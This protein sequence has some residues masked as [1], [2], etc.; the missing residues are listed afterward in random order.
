MRDPLTGTA[1]I[2]MK[3][4]FTAAS[5]TTAERWKQ[6]ESSSRD[7]RINQMWSIHIMKYY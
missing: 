2:R 3:A 5:F 7:E 4:T 1:P 6:P